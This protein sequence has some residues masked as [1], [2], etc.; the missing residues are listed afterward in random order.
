[1][2]KNLTIHPQDCELTRTFR[3]SFVELYS[4]KELHLQYN[5]IDELDERAFSRIPSLRW[6]AQVFKKSC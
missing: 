5:L 4:L 3:R 2:S 6:A 1:M